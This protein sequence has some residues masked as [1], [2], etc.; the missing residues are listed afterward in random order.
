VNSN[1]QLTDLTATLTLVS[2]I[3]SS[4]PQQWHNTVTSLAYTYCLRLGLSTHITHNNI[5]VCMDNELLVRLVSLIPLHI[6][7]PVLLTAG[8]CPSHNHQNQQFNKQGKYTL[9]CMTIAR[10]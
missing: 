5:N 1:E 2:L 9:A 6:H 10:W 8:H 3:T 7:C 4:L